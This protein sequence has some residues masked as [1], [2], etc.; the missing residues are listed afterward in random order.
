MRQRL[1]RG[2]HLQDLVE[3]RVT[4]LTQQGLGHAQG[5]GR[6]GGDVRRDLHGF[7]HQPLRRDHP[8]DQP[9]LHR[10]LRI[11]HTRGEQHFGGPRI[12]DVARHQPGPAVARQNPQLQEGHA[13]TGRV[14]GDANVRQSRDVTAQPHGRAVHRRDQRHL[15][16]VKRPYDPVHHTPVTLPDL[17]TRSREQVAPVLHRPEIATGREG[18]P[19]AGQHHAAHALV[20]IHR[21]TGRS[22]GLAVPEVGQGIEPVGPVQGPEFDVVAAVSA[23]QGHAPDVPHTASRRNVSC[24]DSGAGLRTGFDLVALAKPDGHEI[25]RVADHAVAGPVAVLGIH[26]HPAQQGKGHHGMLQVAVSI[27]HRASPFALAM[28]R[29]T[30]CFSGVSPS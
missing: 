18:S 21:L 16:P 6:A 14:R 7:I 25:R 20:R 13:E 28:K 8:A 10:R 24:P 27:F 11:Q 12:A 5:P 17:G 4:A 1:H 3:G 19:G 23:D 29:D 26:Q 2:G 30:S 15:Q 9:P 22:E